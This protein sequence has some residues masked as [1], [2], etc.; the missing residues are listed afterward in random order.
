ME[1]AL[2]SV[3]LSS[4]LCAPRLLPSGCKKFLPMEDFVE[5]SSSLSFFLINSRDVY[6]FMT[7]SHSNSNQY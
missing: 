2:S 1:I 5:Q 3:T 4:P 7:P 6:P